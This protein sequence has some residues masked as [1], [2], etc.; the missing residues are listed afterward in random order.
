MSFQIDSNHYT[1]LSNQTILIEVF[2][3]SVK[4]T[5]QFNQ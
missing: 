2:S 4:I 5:L 1:S 3:N